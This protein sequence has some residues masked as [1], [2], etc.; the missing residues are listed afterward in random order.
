MSINKYFTIVIS[1][2]FFSCSF[3]NKSGIWQEGNE[4]TNDTKINKNNKRI[5]VF[6]ETEIFQ[7]E[8]LKKTN[9]LLKDSKYNK[10][11]L[12]EYYNLKNNY[13]NFKVKDFSK[14]DV[15]KE[16]Y[17]L[18]LR[19]KLLS[20]KDQLISYDKNA[21]IIVYSLA[22]KQII[23]KY[24]FYKNKFK[25]YKKRIFLT[26]DIENNSVVAADNLGYIYSI[27]L[28]LGKLNWA[29]NFGVPFRSELKIF[30]KQ[31]FISN[32]DNVLYSLSS[33]SGKKNWQLLTE[34]GN[35][36]SNFKNSLVIDS[37]NLFFLNSVG[38]LHSINHVNQKINWI[39]A[40]S[41]PAANSKFNYYD[42]QPITLYA[43][44]LIL[45]SSSRTILIDALSGNT[46][47][48][49]PISNKLKPVVIQ[50]QL[51]LFSS[52]NFLISINF[53]GKINWSRNINKMLKKDFD[54]D[55]KKVGNI[56][57]IMIVNNAL[58]A[59]TERGGIINFNV[60]DGSIKEIVK[61]SKEKINLYPI[62]ISKK[63]LYINEKGSLIVYF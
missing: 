25:K 40:V 1:L 46:I 30:D 57:S 53:D 9:L 61:I 16:K 39:T 15:T 38:K 55:F 4:L 41:Q 51:Y 23:V 29:Q 48:S 14:D 20:Y 2:F 24:N 54:N 26:I 28:N 52:N 33:K 44:K 60:Q 27:D 35:L 37:Q 50:K 49:K 17:N 43:D 58:Q 63:L 36:K 42:G 18:K 10:S 56:K 32:Q 21:N 7:E 22:K 8:V 13:Q 34:Q 62:Y 31:I 19:G 12:N 5:K 45:T 47:W 6:K 59:I 3:D 11:W